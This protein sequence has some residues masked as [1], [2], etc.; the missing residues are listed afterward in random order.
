MDLEGTRQ[1][2]QQIKERLVTAQSRQ[3]SYA[4]RQRRDLEFAV[5]DKEFLKLTPRRSFG[6]FKRDR[7]L[8]PRFIRPFSIVQRIGKVAYRLTLPTELQGIHNVFHVSQLRKYLA[9]PDHVENDENIDLTTDLNYVEKP[10]QILD[11][12]EKKF[13]QKTIPLVKVLWNRHPVQDAT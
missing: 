11:H 3:K 1:K 5:G 7:K 10:V 8:Q 2:M 12:G 6:K 9:D 13:R 4:D